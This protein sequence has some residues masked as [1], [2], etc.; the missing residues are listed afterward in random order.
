VSVIDLPMENQFF[1]NAAGV[2]Q[3]QHPLHF[4]PSPPQPPSSVPSWQSLSPTMAIQPTLLNCASDQTQ[5]CFY[6]PN[7]DKSTDHGLHFDSSALSSMVSSPAASSNP[8]SNSTMSNENF[9]IRELVGR[10]GAI[11]SSDEIP[12]HSPHHPLV[13]ASSYMNNGSNSPNTSCYN[14]PLSSPPKVKTVQSLVN[15]RLANLGG[16]SMTLNSSVAEFSADPGFAERAAKFSCFGSRSFN[17]RNVQLGVNNGEL[18]QRSTAVVENG[19]KLS[20]ISSSPL[21][22]TLGSQM[23]TQENKNSAIQD[24][25]KMEVA[26]SQEESTISEQTPNGEIGM[27]IC[28][29]MTNSRKRKASSKGKTRETSNSINPTKVIIIIIIII[30]IFEV[31]LLFCY[32]F[33]ILHKVSNYGHGCG[34]VSFLILLEIVTYVVN[35]ASQFCNLNMSF[36]IQGVE[37]SEDSNSK[38]SKP[39]EGEGNENGQVKVEEESKAVEEKQNKSNS[40]PPEP[41]KDYIHVRA[42]RGQATDSHSLAERVRVSAFGSN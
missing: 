12:Q 27:K 20:R 18:A 25:E 7:W 29:D 33:F 42:R 30:T 21:L 14:T 8:N 40:K 4:E 34:F 36:S 28:Q 9:M 39:N 13:V 5:D 2:S 11:G 17:G 38:R 26:N 3:P 10:L 19:G 1:L 15:E 32:G 41:P 22:K 24:Q 16:K 6:N 37:V 35:S 23:G 31:K